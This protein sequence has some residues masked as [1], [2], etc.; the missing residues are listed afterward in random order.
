MCLC[1]HPNLQ[2]TQKIKVFQYVEKHDNEML[3]A[4]ETLHVRLASRCF[5]TNVHDFLAVKKLLYLTIHWLSGKIAIFDHVYAFVS[6]Y[7]Q[8]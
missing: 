8:K 6:C 1:L 5:T 7:K 2:F 4:V 3:I